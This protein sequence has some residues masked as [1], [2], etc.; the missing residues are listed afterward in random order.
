MQLPISYI[1]LRYLHNSAEMLCTLLECEQQA[2]HYQSFIYLRE[3]FPD[4]SDELVVS[5]R[6]LVTQQLGR[7]V[8]TEQVQVG[9]GVHSGGQKRNL[10]FTKHPPRDSMMQQSTLVIAPKRPTLGNDQRWT[11]ATIHMTSS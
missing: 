3:V 1:L 6:Q 9:V 8:A 11:A 2:P 4:R 5:Q 7:Y 10:S